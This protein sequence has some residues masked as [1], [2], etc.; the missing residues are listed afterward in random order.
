MVPGC[1]TGA[2]HYSDIELAAGFAIEVAKAFVSG[3]CRFYDE[4][5]FKRIEERYGS[6]KHILGFGK[7]A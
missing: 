2:G 3:S 4:E 6:M 1:A 5:E 7:E